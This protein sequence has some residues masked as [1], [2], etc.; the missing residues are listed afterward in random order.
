MMTIA[1]MGLAGPLAMAVCEGLRLPR[2]RYT[3]NGGMRFLRI[4]KLQ[5]SWCICRRG[6]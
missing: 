3:R 1:V 2:V 6:I 4:G 5:M